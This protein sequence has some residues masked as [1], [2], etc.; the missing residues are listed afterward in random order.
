MYLILSIIR[1]YL[2]TLLPFYLFTFLPFY[3][4]RSERESADEVSLLGGGVGSDT[5]EE[6]YG[7][8]FRDLNVLCR[9]Q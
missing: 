7:P 9:A 3:L 4:S 6:R 5:G 8:A 2:F 1:F